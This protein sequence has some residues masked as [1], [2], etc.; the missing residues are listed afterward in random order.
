MSNPESDSISS[1]HKRWIFTN[2]NPTS[3]K[4]SFI[5]AIASLITN[6][7]VINF[8]ITTHNLVEFI[9][10]SPIIVTIFSATLLFDYLSLKGTP[11][12]RFSK[13]LHV[14]AFASILWTLTVILR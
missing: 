8:V 13:V 7:I 10:P 11:L 3:Q 9:T 5:I 1:L 12:N 14:A 2:I 4:F 6:I